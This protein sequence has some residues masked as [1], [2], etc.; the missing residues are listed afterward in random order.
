MKTITFYNLPIHSGQMWQFDRPTYVYES[1]TLDIAVLE[2][3]SRILI[4]QRAKGVVGIWYEILYWGQVRL[5][6]A[7]AL[8][9]S[10]HLSRENKND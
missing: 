5:I 3:E 7:Q 9:E 4:A 2:A 6:E 8:M 1:N 10:A